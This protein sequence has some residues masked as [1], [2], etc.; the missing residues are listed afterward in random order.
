[1][2]R[3]KKST[4]LWVIIP[5]VILILLIFNSCRL[6][7]QVGSPTDASVDCQLK[8]FGGMTY[9]IVYSSS[10][11][12]IANIT[13]DS[14]EVTTRRRAELYIQLANRQLQKK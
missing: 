4:A 6:S 12:Q 8:Q 14:L 7:T 10:G 13:R 5:I 2:I 1:M 9:L 11:I 3:Q